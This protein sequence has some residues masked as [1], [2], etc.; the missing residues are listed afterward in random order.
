MA[1]D[2]IVVG[3]GFTGAT[4]AERM[5]TAGRRVRIV[6]RRAHIAGNAY[7]EIN[8]SGILVHD[9]APISFTPTAMWY[10]GISPVSQ[11]GAR[12]SIVC[13]V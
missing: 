3:A 4:F 2:W 11:S 6:E 13:L 9:M 12:M 1:P 5:A 10:G 8:Q 7:D